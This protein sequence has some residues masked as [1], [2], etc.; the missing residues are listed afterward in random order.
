MIRAGRLYRV[1]GTYTAPAASLSSLKNR[2]DYSTT[3]GTKHTVGK[4]KSRGGKLLKVTSADLMT[5]E[6]NKTR[7]KKKQHNRPIYYT[8]TPCSRSI[9]QQDQQQNIYIRLLPPGK[10]Y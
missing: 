5:T 3:G 7:K 6:E 1:D 2:E 8:G 10:Q 4:I 9:V